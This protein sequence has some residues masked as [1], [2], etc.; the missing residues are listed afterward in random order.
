M[1]RI[2]KRH[3][4]SFK[5]QV[6]LEAAKQAKTIA[7]LAKQF[8]VHPVQISQWKNQLLDGMETLFQNG[9]TRQP[10]PEK[11]QTELYEQI[12]RLQMELAWV[13]KNPPREVQSKRALIESEHPQLS[14]RRQC[15]LLGLNRA[16]Y[17]H[18]PAR[19]TIENL[20]LMRRIDE[21]YLKTPFFGSRRMAAWLTREGE[22]VNRKRVKR[23]MGLMGLEAI[24][25]GPRTTVHNPDHKVYPYLLRG[26]AIERRDQVWSSDITYIP[27]HQG[28]MYLTA[29][30]DWHSRYVL[31]WSLSNSL[32]SRFCL[33]TLE[34]CDRASAKDFGGNRTIFGPRGRSVPMTTVPEA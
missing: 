11:L 26:V 30:I 16:S 23:L 28:F 4:P 5:A 9:T 29:V 15:E 18:E 12:G 14:I 32:D 6:A 19:E 8:Q 1:A 21:Q 17:Y 20:R 33:E 3:S 22:E 24:H 13:K 31:S 7:E 25:P 2:R 27:M 34:G 10:D